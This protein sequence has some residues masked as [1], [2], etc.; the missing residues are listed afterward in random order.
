FDVG[1]TLEVYKSDFDGARDAY[2]KVRGFAPSSQFATRAD[3]RSKN[4]ER[5]RSLH[6]TA[7]DPAEAAFTAAELLLLD[8]EK[9]TEALAQYQIVQR[10]Y[11]HSEFAPKA[12]YAI[13]WTKL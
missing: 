4:L 2:A 12:G 7:A 9:P 6:L 11:P 13:A 10:R 5:L 8:L 1:Y 3:S